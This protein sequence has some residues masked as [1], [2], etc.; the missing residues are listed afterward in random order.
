MRMSWLYRTPALPISMR[1]YVAL[2]M[3]AAKNTFS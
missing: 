2:G 3:S 1:W